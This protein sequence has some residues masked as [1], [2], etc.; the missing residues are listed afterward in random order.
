VHVEHV[1]FFDEFSVD[2][3]AFQFPNS[4]PTDYHDH[5]CRL[6]EVHG[7][8]ESTHWWRS[9]GLNDRPSVLHLS[10]RQPVE[11]AILKF[12]IWSFAFNTAKDEDALLLNL[13]SHQVPMNI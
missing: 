13:L 6:N 12:I 7:V 10:D 3:A 9:T 4:A 5:V 1:R 8:L 2:V 11:V